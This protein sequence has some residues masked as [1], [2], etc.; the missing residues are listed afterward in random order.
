MLKTHRHRHNRDSLATHDLS[1][2]GRQTI[3]Q[4]HNKMPP[5][6]GKHTHNFK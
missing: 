3:K 1:V 5:A 2:N 6:R 4:S